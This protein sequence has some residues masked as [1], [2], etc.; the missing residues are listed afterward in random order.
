MGKPV[1]YYDPSRQL[2]R[3]VELTD[4]I[5][6]PNADRLELAII[7]GWQVVVGKG[8]WIKGQRALYCEPGSLLPT[9]VPEFMGADREENIKV[10]NDVAYAYIKSIRLRQEMSQ[11]FVAPVPKEF[12][13]QPTGTDLTLK[14]GA[15]KYD[16]DGSVPGLL[17]SANIAN[18]SLWNRFIDF[19]TGEI[20]SNLLSFPSDVATKSDQPRVQNI[21]GRLTAAEDDETYEETV[22]LDGN[23][24]TVYYRPVVDE[25]GVMTVQTGIAT[26]EREIILKPFKIST[27]KALRVFIGLSINQIRRKLRGAEKI[28]W[29]EYSEWVASP[30]SHFQ[31]A[32]EHLEITGVNRRMCAVATA[33]NFRGSAVDNGVTIALQGEII[34]PNVSAGDRKNHEGVKKLG[35]YVFNVFVNGKELLP[36]QAQLFCEDHGV[37][38]VPV[39][40]KAATVKGIPMKELI[41]R[42]DGPRFFTNDGNREGLV[43]KSNKTGFSFK[44]VS[45]KFILKNGD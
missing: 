14:L 15:L 39:L 35:F 32:F 12:S 20:P 16:A 1:A 23:S 28:Y 18:K 4:V 2:V 24:A 36:E 13:N 29:P 45:N 6:H 38:Y 11:G 7:E 30:R 43:Y 17:P 8:I 9:T 31:E 37:Q 21:A 25:E 27:F 34:G 42:A 26:R 22:K 5:P 3:I 40:N 19:I 10:F 41:E 44:I 33:P